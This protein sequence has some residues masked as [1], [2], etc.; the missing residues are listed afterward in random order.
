MPTNNFYIGQADG[1]VQ[2]A[3]ANTEVRVT[4]APHTHP[5]YL[6]AGPT[7]PA[8]TVEGILV[9]H[10]PFQTTNPMTDLLYARIINPVPNAKQMDG[11]I[12]LDVFTIV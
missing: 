8:D 3:P 11:K 9:C 6:Y 1:W 12:R 4:G 2:I 7:P 10:H 5:Y